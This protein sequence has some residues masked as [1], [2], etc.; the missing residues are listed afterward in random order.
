M[1]QGIN[2][3]RLAVNI[4]GLVAVFFLGRFIFKKVQ[5][6][7]ILRE[8][9]K[10]SNITR[11]RKGNS[12]GSQQPDA[13]YEIYARQLKEMMKGIDWLNQNEPKIVD[14]ISQMDCKT[15]KGVELAFNNTYGDGQTLD[16]WLADDLGSSNLEK[17]R[18]LLN[19]S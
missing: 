10:L 12:L 18:N 7:K 15:R 11:D 13:D 5:E 19:C 17:V 8:Y 6:R 2:Y 9:G 14:L 1:N 3:T 16:T 4:G